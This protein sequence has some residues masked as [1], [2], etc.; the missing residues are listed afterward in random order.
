M[1][2]LTVLAPNES[3]YCSFSREKSGMA[4]LFTVRERGRTTCKRG[5]RVTWTNGS[6]CSVRL[7]PS[8]D[9]KGSAAISEFPSKPL[10][11]K[12]SAADCL[13]TPEVS[14]WIKSRSEG[15]MP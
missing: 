2:I 15:D 6:F 13:A 1:D 9:R 11:A 8:W 14:K 7:A 4:A 5:V 3:N 12:D 10:S